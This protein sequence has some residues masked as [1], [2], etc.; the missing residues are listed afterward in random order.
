VDRVIVATL[1]DANYRL[2]EQLEENDQALMDIRALLK[3]ESNDCG[4]RKPFA[5]SI[6][7]YCWTHGYKIAKNHKSVKC[8]YP[9]NEHNRD[10]T[11]S[12]TMGGSQTNKE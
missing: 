11:K 4:A 6:D 10:T 12:N 1:T 3:K 5:P 7:N 9:N 2:T 8:M